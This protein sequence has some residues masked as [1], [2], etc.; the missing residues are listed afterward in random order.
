MGTG[1]K[2]GKRGRKSNNLPVPSSTPAEGKFNLSIDII[3][4]LAKIDVGTPSSQAEVPDVLEKL[5]AKVKQWKADQDKKTKEVRGDPNI[6]SPALFLRYRKLTLLLNLEHCQ[7]SSR[8]R[9]ARNRGLR[10][11]KYSGQCKLYL[12]RS[13]P[14]FRQ[15]ALA[16]ECGC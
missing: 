13:C 16:S 12:R 5:V 11:I 1:G 3:E 14:R 15:E 10:G 4:E 7:G 9:S 8:S 2:K 6:L